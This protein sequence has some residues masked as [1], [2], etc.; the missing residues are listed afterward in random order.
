MM[1]T[2]HAPSF[3]PM[4]ARAFTVRAAAPV[5][6]EPRAP[7]KKAA[8]SLPAK[9]RGDDDGRPRRA[10]PRA[11]TPAVPPVET[12][13]AA[14][15]AWGRL[16]GRARP[17]FARYL[18]NDKRRKYD[19]LDLLQ[20]QPLLKQALDALADTAAAG[21]PVLFVG[22]SPAAREVRH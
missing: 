20:T 12:L 10:S 4:A 17:G 21:H 19:V 7:R 16:A 22:T 6:R 9:P 13:L 8:A 1:M 11:P 5:P 15:A 3:L 14:G 2:Q 18:F